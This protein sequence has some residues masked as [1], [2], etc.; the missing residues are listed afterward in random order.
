WDVGVALADLP[1]DVDIPPRGNLELDP[2]VALGE[3]LIDQLVERPNLALDPQAHTRGDLAESPAEQRRQ[4]LLLAMRPS[5]PVGH[6]GARPGEVVSL[7]QAVEPDQ[8]SDR[9]PRSADHRGR[10]ELRQDVP[11]RLGRLRAIVRVRGA[12]A[13]TPA[14]DAVTLD[15]HQDVGDL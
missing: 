11:A 7:D 1:H 6:R 9:F 4:R 12:G 10:K 5:L 3:I 2:A 14:D 8:F 15:A 13:L